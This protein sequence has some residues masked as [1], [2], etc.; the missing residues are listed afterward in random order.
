MREIPDDVGATSGNREQLEL[1]A[2]EIERLKKAQD[3]L[4]DLAS[5]MVAFAGNETWALYAAEAVRY[6]PRHAAEGL[7]GLSNRIAT[8]DP[9]A[10]ALSS[11][12]GQGRSA[13][14]RRYAWRLITTRA[15]IAQCSVRR[16]C[17]LVRAA[18]FLQSINRSVL[19]A[20]QTYLHAR[21]VSASGRRC[22]D[23]RQTA[24]EIDGAERTA[25]A[26]SQAEQQHIRTKYCI[27]SP[28]V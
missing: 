23:P 15:A 18:A 6:D 7:I 3:V 25:E 26:S 20:A 11:E 16:K 13:S 4:R 27:V 12:N 1:S 14:S 17:F 10:P 19:P 22:Q 8:I 2:E 24:P 21:A 28:S 9:Q 5:Q